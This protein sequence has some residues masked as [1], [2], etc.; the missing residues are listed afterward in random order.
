[1]MRFKEKGKKKESLIMLD[2]YCELT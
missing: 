1:M 2:I